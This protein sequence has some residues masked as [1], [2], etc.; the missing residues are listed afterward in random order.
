M[1]TK[2]VLFENDYYLKEDFGEGF[3]CW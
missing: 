1:A 2:Y 3:C